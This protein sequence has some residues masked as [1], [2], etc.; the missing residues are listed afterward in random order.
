MNFHNTSISTRSDN[1][2]KKGFKKYQ[3]KL[4]VI[5]SDFYLSDSQIT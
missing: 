5:T 2:F 4:V 1:R 3:S